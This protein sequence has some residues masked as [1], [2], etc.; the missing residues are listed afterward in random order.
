[1]LSE[2]LIQKVISGNVL[3]HFSLLLFPVVQMEGG[4]L[5]NYGCQF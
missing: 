4:G 2:E 3:L 5:F 1:M